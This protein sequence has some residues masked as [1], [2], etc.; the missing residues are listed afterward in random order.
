MAASSTVTT[1][2]GV[3][4]PAVDVRRS[5]AARADA[6]ETCCSRMICTSVPHLESRPQSGGGPKRS[7]TAARSRSR[8]PSS[9][10]ATARVS[11]LRVVIPIEGCPGRSRHSGE[12]GRAL[13][14][15][16]DAASGT[17]FLIS[18]EVFRMACSRAFVRGTGAL[19]PVIVIVLVASLAPYLGATAAAAAVIPSGTAVVSAA[20]PTATFNPNL[21]LTGSSSAA[22]PSIRTDQFGQSFVIGP[23]GVPAGCKAFRIRHDGSASTFLGFPDHTAGG[24]DCDWAIGPQETAALVG[25]GTPTDS[26]LAYSSLTAANITVGKSNDGGTTFGPPNPGAAQVGGD[27]RMWQ[28]ADPK[29]NSGGFD[30]VFMSYHDVTTGNIDVSISVDGG[31]TYVQSTP[32]INPIEVPVGQWSGDL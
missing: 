14:G 22:E 16:A 4:A 1:R 23:T 17:R 10:T 28:A 27:D 18:P 21:L 5:Y 15:T 12:R 3:M 9:A 24:G 13:A 19:S 7:T 29:L 32:L 30:T 11:A 2:S 25:F 26:G 8:V 6:S 20:P 31:Q